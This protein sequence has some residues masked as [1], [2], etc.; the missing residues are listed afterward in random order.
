MQKIG[1]LKNYVILEEDGLT[2]MQIR[3]PKGMKHYYRLENLVVIMGR[4]RIT[5]L[6]MNDANRI[7]YHSTEIMVVESCSE[8]F[9]VGAR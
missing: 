8:C 6:I 2:V 5:N 7:D 1:K 9:I 3:S 4:T